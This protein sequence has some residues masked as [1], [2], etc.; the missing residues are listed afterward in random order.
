M[1]W[2]RSLSLCLSEYTNDF[3][4]F[5]YNAV[6]TL[7]SYT[8]L[9]YLYP[10]RSLLANMALRLSLLVSTAL[11]LLLSM[12]AHCH[13]DFERECLAFTPEAYVSNSTRQVLEYVPAGTNLMFPDNDPTCARPS[14]VVSADLCRVALL[15]PTSKRSSITFEMWLPVQWSGRFLGTGNG[16]IDGCVY[17][18]SIL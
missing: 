2:K 10:R 12:L 18:I 13:N 15:I 8:P 9:A 3:Y 1:C 11:C 7:I 4:L 14:Q 6:T 17:S 16:G 5:A